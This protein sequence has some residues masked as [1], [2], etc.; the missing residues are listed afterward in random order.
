MSLHYT[1]SG[2]CVY[3]LQGGVFIA[4]TYFLC[5][6]VPDRGG[7]MARKSQGSR[8]TMVRLPAGVRRELERV[9]DLHQRSLSA[10]V[11]YRLEQSLL[12]ENTPKERP[13]QS[14]EQIRDELRDVRDELRELRAELRDVRQDI[15][16][17]LPERE[18][19][20]YSIPAKKD[21]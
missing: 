5:H 7:L 6:T 10:E 14:E 2:A 18:Q 3:S 8:P 1:L 16:H 21:D 12:S 19:P 9:A 20:S 13:A 11:I 4:Y 15:S 17:I